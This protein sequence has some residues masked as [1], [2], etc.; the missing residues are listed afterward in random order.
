MEEKKSFENITDEE[1]DYYITFVQRPPAPR[2]TSQRVI[3]DDGE[4]ADLI[5]EEP[6][7]DRTKNKVNGLIPS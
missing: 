1:D 5:F 2:R 4:Q 7:T 6:Y 3:F